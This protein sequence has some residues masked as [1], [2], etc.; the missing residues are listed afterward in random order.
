MGICSVKD[1]KGMNYCLNETFK[2]TMAL[3]P[4]VWKIGQITHLLIC[5]GI[6]DTQTYATSMAKP[7]FSL[8]QRR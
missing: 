3:F 7:P 6:D 5:D 8:V 1:T 2:N 4:I